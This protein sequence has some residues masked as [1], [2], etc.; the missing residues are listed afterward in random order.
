LAA[1]VVVG[2]FLGWSSESA[3]RA[4]H[5]WNSLA[6]GWSPQAAQPGLTLVGGLVLVVLFGKA[7]VS[8][9]FAQTAWTN[10]TFVGS[11]VRDPG[12]NLARSLLYGCAI[13]VVL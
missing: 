12:R 1:V 11:E 3:A 4:S 7:M 5:W 10:V 8:P 9:L 2:L 6:N 13:T